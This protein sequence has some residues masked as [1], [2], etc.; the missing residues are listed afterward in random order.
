MPEPVIVAVPPKGGSLKAVLRRLVAAAWLPAEL[1]DGINDL[2]KRDKQR[3]KLEETLIRLWDGHHDSEEAV[4]AAAQERGF[5]D[6]L[7]DAAL[8]RMLRYRGK[9]GRLRLAFTPKEGV[10]ALLAEWRCDGDPRI[11]AAAKTLHLE[12]DL[13]RYGRP[14]RMMFDHIEFEWQEKGGILGRGVLVGTDHEVTPTY[15]RRH[16]RDIS[17]TCY[18]AFHN[19]LLD[20]LDTGKVRNWSELMEHLIESNTDVRI[21]GSLGLDDYLGHFV[22][23]PEEKARRIAALDAG[24]GWNH[25]DGDAKLACLA[26]EPVL[27]DANYEGIYLNLLDGERNGIDFEHTTRDIESICA[28]EGRTAI[29]IVQ[30]GGTIARM[31][32]L[33]VVDEELLTSETIVAVNRERL[34]HNRRVGSLVDSLAPSAE[35]RSDRWRQRLADRLGDRLI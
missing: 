2:L 29:Y 26:E 6:K 5:D 12:L 32:G 30:S 11:A 25:V 1:V 28:H 27:I 10:D 17:L 3:I 34:D 8:S 35:D 9:A 18:D 21:L 31:P 19:T 22:L 13:T 14:S 23:M 24:R 7:I 20:A 33:C 16:K 15:L 4:V